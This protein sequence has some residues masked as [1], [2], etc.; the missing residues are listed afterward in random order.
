MTNVT[1]V[2]VDIP[3]GLISDPQATPQC[4]SAE[5]PSC[6]TSTQLGVVQMELYTAGTDQ[7][8]GASVYNMVPPAGKVSDYAFNI[9][10]VNVRT[11]VI[12][13]IR[14]ASDDGL[15][16]TIAVPS[17]VLPAELVHSALIFWGVPGDSAHAP[18]L[19]LVVRGNA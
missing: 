1:N 13:G 3:P 10:V 12:G 5:F 2:R 7:W 19:R 9:P 18:D 8:F 11:D 4:T 14:S 17:S 6:P 16:F 15:Y